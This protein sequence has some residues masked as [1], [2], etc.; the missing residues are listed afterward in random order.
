LTTARVLGTPG[1]VAQRMTALF[2]S[3]SIMVTLSP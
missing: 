2:G 1:R 3:A